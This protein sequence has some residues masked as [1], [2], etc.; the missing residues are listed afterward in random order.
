VSSKFSIG[1]CH[2]G[3]S[4]VSILTDS[5]RVARLNLRGLTRWPRCDVS[6]LEKKFA[7]QFGARYALATTSCTGALVTALVACGVGPGC[8]VIVNGYTFFASCA[9]IVGAKAIP[10]ICVH[11]ELTGAVML[12]QL[13]LAPTASRPRLRRTPGL[14]GWPQPRCDGILLS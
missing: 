14:P 5:V 11:S 12:A 8:E 2:V 7:A 6:E 4:S 10:V 3:Q 9:A 13:S 1:S